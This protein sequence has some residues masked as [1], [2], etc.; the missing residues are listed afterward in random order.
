MSKLSWHVFAMAGLVTAFSGSLYAVDGVILIDQPHA[1]AGNITPGDAPGFPVTLSQPGSYRL[2]GN[3]SVPDAATT[4]IQI[5]ADGVTLDMNGFSIIGP[6][7]CTALSTGMGAN[8]PAASTGVGILAAQPNGAGGPLGVKVYNGT[9]KGMGLHG[10]EL[11]GFGSVV[12][13]VTAYSNAGDGML[14]AGS[15][16]GSAVMQNGK[17]GLL[18]TVVRETFAF[19]NAGD[20]IVLDGIGGTAFAVISSFNGGNGVLSQNGIVTNSTIVRNVLVGIS[21]RC[22]SSLVNNNIVNNQGGTIV[23]ESPGCVS[24]NN[25]LL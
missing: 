20:G 8:C 14:V 18:A 22:P 12:E 23:T 24:V 15:I 3:L 21:A 2:S 7:T 13:K 19:Q 4:A 11:L 6:V 5:T 25:G 1:L 9:V 10:I 17:V 16:I